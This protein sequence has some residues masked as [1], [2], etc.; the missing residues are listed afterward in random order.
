RM[1][2]SAHCWTSPSAPS[3]ATGSRRGWCSANG[4]PT[5]SAW[6]EHDW[7]ALEALLDAVLDEPPSTRA[8]WVRRHVRDPRLGATVA[9]M[10]AADDC[11]GARLE[12][13][14]EPAAARVAAMEGASIRPP[15]VPGYR[16]LG[17][18]G[19]GGMGSVFL[20]ER[21]LGEVVQR[22]ALKRLR[23]GLYDPVAR[24]RF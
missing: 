22:V 10:L 15:E 5:M 6:S 4:L 1:R 16:V 13:C 17:L 24:R 2:K 18:L 14:G 20:A 9:A 19:E 7:P 12:R 11:I 8:A 21:L 3:N 23:N